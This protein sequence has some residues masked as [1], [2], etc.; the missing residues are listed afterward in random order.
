MAHNDFKTALVQTLGYK[1]ISI[2]FDLL[3][4]CVY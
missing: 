3:I 2:Y 4:G 1:L